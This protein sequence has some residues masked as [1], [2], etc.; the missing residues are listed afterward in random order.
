MKTLYLSFLWHMHQPYYKDNTENKYFMPYAFLHSIKDYYDM[1][2]HVSKYKDIKCTFNLTPSLLY[3]INDLSKN[4]EQ[5]IFIYVLLKDVDSLID[6]E[7]IFL[8][9]GLFSVNY[10]NAIKPVKYYDKL[11]KKRKRANKNNL[12]IFSDNELLDLEV[13]YLLAN[14]GYYLKKEDFVKKLIN[15]GKWFTQKEKEDLVYYLKDFLGKIIPLYRSMR[16]EGRISTTTSPFYHPILPLLVD[17]ENAKKARQDVILPKIEANF[18]DDADLQIKKALELN[19]KLLDYEPDGFWPSE[20]SVS[21][22]VIELFRKNGIKYI[23]TD[24]DVLFKT[25]KNSDRAYVYK[26]YKINGVDV[27]FRDKNLSNDISFRYNALNS[28]DAVND[29]ISHLRGIYDYHEFSPVVSVVMD[30]ENAW[31]FYKNNGYDFFEE[32]YRQLERLNWCKTATFDEILSL[33]EIEREDLSHIEPGSWI[34]GNFDIWIGKKEKNV[35]WDMLALA[36]NECDAKNRD[37]QEEILEAEGSDWFWWY[38][39]D[40][41]TPIKEQFDALFRKHLINAYRES[42][43]DVPSKLFKPITKITPKGYIPKQTTPIMPSIDGRLSFAF[44]WLESLI[45]KAKPEKAMFN[46]MRVCFDDRFTYI[47]LF[48]DKISFK[49][50]CA[51]EFDFLDKKV[52]NLNIPLKNSSCERFL[53]KTDE[54]TEIRINGT[55]EFEYAVLRVKIENKTKEE[56]FFEKVKY[57]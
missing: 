56:I 2:M 39:D 7:K 24:E 29:F 8:L 43:K 44:E 33:K 4:L 49:E 34:Y 48:G 10:E 37:V 3:Q 16:K 19:K 11:Y 32:L 41:Y 27:F 38:D 42:L 14:C 21:D 46:T 23:L 9:N 53:I 1:L 31:E 5:D 17:R 40:F 22:G 54:F 25:I 15:K 51:L 57:E 12:D 26:V 30:G 36:K 55:F 35:A 28:K 47:A 50:N 20:G 18:K 52:F 13:L 45:F 6:N